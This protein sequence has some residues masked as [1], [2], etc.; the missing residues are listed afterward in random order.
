MQIITNTLEL[1]SPN[2]SLF[3]R[4]QE[5]AFSAASP[6]K[7]LSMNILDLS[8]QL[9]YLSVELNPIY[10]LQHIPINLKNTGG[11]LI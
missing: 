11:E 9:T 2:T 8:Y 5:V 10:S 3:S 6:C 1:L 7:A 4:I